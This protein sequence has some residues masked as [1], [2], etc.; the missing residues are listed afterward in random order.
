MTTFITVLSQADMRAF[1]APPIFS[2]EER[3]SFFELPQWA[4]NI[5][6][7][8]R[9]PTNKAGFVLQLGYFRATNKFFNPKDFHISDIAFVARA[10]SIP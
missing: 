5:I 6:N 4:D 7:T 3:S 2:E 10:L 1:E 9:T 8:L